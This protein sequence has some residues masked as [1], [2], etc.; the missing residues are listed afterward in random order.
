MHSI[1]TQLG[2]Y[3]ATVVFGNVLLQQIGLPIP[4]EPSLVVAGSM[5]AR[6]S[7][8][9]SKL[10]IAVV[11]AGLLADTTWFFLGRRYQEPVLRLLAR[12]SRSG[13]DLARARMIFARWGL[14]PLLFAKFLPGVSQVL[15]PVAG[16]S[17]VKLRSFIFYDVA[18]TLFWASLPVGGGLLF[19]EQVSAVMT[20]LSR[21]ALWLGI[22]ALMAAGAYL[23]T[24][25]F[26][27]PR[28]TTPSAVARGE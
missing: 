27:N 2:Q 22:G 13:S 10:S 16:A 24:R 15:V 4:A 20:W 7:L 5:V 23:L 12:L 26:S 18:G 8:P 1:V 25:R 9:F 6:G 14:R 17:G 28:N 11:A 21:L 3:G 19:H